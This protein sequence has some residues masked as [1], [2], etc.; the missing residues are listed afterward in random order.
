VLR[1]GDIA[2]NW[3]AFPYASAAD[4]FEMSFPGLLVVTHDQGVWQLPH[5]DSLCYDV[6]IGLGL[7][8]GFGFDIG[9]G[10]VAWAC[11]VAGPPGQSVAMD[12]G[13]Y[14]LVRSDGRSGIGDPVPANLETWTMPLG[15][16]Y[17]LTFDAC[18]NG[19]L[20]RA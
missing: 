3:L 5:Y 14:Q 13:A 4:R 18:G 12:A 19:V 8:L 7:G 16:Q 9:P 10:A 2:A 20:Q 6:A 11:S 17:A 1:K 15:Y